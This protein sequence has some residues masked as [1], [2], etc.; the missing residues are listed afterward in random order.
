MW[1]YLRW[2]GSDYLVQLNLKDTIV[3]G[4]SLGVIEFRP[5]CIK[6]Y[7]AACFRIT[8][9][10][11][12]AVVDDTNSCAT[13]CLSQLR[14]YGRSVHLWSQRMKYWSFRIL[15]NTCALEEHSVQHGVLATKVK[16]WVVQSYTHA[17]NVSSTTS[18]KEW[19]TTPSNVF[20]QK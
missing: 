11:S 19:S 9:A 13:V 16:E 2:F 3:I 15:V 4:Q 12:W 10:F 8:P 18:M 1:S 14:K 7:Y 6:Y 5:E 17:R 20:N